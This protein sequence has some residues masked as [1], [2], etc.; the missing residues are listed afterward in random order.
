MTEKQSAMLWLLATLAA[1]IIVGFLAGML[2]A[3][4]IS[5]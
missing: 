3:I 1:G 2:F 5:S 4:K